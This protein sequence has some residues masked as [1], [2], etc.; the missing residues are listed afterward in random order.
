LRHH[1]SKRIVDHSQL[2]CCN[3]VITTYQTVESE[4]RKLADNNPSALFSV[5]WR[6]I[7]LDEGKKMVHIVLEKVT[8]PTRTSTAIYF[9]LHT[10]ISSRLRTIA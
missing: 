3:V 10:L 9:L 5:Y 4:W 6:R 1:S 8:T 7:I 2:Q